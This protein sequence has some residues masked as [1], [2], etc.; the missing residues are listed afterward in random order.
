MSVVAVQHPTPERCDAI[1]VVVVAV[2]VVIVVD[3]LSPS[4]ALRVSFALE[5]EK[6]GYYCVIPGGG[7]VDGAR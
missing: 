3:P 1:L 2:V 7:K 4:H 5:G 6:R